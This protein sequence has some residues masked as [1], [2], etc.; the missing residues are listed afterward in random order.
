MK[1]ASKVTY[2]N[3]TT[4]QRFRAAIA[5]KA[6]GDENEYQKLKNQSPDGDYVINKLSARVY[7]FTIM[8]MAIR[9]DILDCLSKWLL[10]QTISPCDQETE[11]IQSSVTEKAFRKCDSLIAA[12]DRWLDSLGISP[13]TYAAFDAPPKVCHK[14]SSMN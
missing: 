13:R 8:T 7:D 10:S 6:R 9:L 4:A 3:L 1:T 2:Q 5:A 11:A 12:R 14:T